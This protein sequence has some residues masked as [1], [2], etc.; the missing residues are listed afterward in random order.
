M[1][2]LFPL[3]FAIFLFLVFSSWKHVVVDTDPRAEALTFL[4][5]VSQGGLAKTVKHFG[6]NTCRC[7][8]KGGWGSYLIYQSGAESNL[9]FMTGHPFATGTP[10]AHV[11]VNDRPA[12]LPWQKP[13]DYVIDVPIAFDAHAYAPLFLPLPMAYGDKM[14]KDQLD[15]FIKDPDKDAWKGFTLRMRPS[16]EPGAIAPPKEPLPEDAADE[17][18]DLK[19]PAEDKD[20]K[21]KTAEEKDDASTEE[22]VK[23]ALGA[24]AAKYLKPKDAGPVVDADGKVIPADK[25]A[26]LLPHLRSAIMRLHVVR[27][28]EVNDWTIY[29]FGL[30]YPVLDFNDGR[31]VKLTHDRRPD[32]LP[33]DPTQGTRIHPNQP[34]EWLRNETTE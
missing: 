33:K 22:A 27:R 16:I 14:T 2:I 29:H 17:F 20:S 34:E 25:V 19:K 9:A 18:K 8:A 28:G 12:L 10:S 4:K 1:R 24:D 6:G 13:Q 30:M 11:L 26:A 15:D 5:D 3:I 7:P 21:N 31:E 23:K 32:W